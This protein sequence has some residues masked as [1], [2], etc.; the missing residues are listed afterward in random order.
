MLKGP[1]AKGE[2]GQGMAIKIIKSAVEYQIN[3]VRNFDLSV[4]LLIPKADPM[5]IKKIE[6]SIKLIWTSPKN[7]LSKFLT[8]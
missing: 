3:K 1:C 6:M 7:K 5:V 8:A 2:K 4:T